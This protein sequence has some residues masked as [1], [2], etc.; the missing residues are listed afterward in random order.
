MIAQ[1]F[2]HDDEDMPIVSYELAFPRQRR[3][4]AADGAAVSM[5]NVSDQTRQDVPELLSDHI[6]W[7]PQVEPAD[8]LDYAIAA[9]SGV[10]AGLIDS[11][12]VGEFSLDHAGEWG[13][14]TIE[15]L[16][17]EIARIEGYKGDSLKDAI[18]N[19]EK[20][21]PI[22]ADGNTA[23]F[24][25]GRQ[26][27]LRD[28]AHHF[29]IGGLVASIFTQFT[30]LSI[31]TD[32]SGRLIIMPVPED[33]RRYLGG[34]VPEKLV[35]GTVE[36]FFH[37]VS[38]MAGSSAN[39]GAGTGIPGPLLS[40]MKELS[41][42]PFFK[43][44]GTDGMGFRLWLSK[45]FNGTFL[46]KHGTDGK[47]VKGTERRFD[48]RMEI[49]VLGEVGRQSM[50][51]VINQCVVRAF[52]FC[53]RLS[54]GIKT[55]G[56]HDVGDIGRIA[57][58]DV[59]P[60]GTPAMRR[61]L[62]VSNGV[63]TGVDIADAAVHAMARK[64]AREFLLRVNYIGIATFV[65]SCVVDVKA[66]MAEG[67]KD[68]AQRDGEAIERGLTELDCLKLD[69]HEARL[70]HSLMRQKVLHDIELEKHDKH[71]KRKRKWLDEWS[72]RLV[73]TIGA[74]D[75]YFLD[76]TPLYGM[77]GGPTGPGA[78]E[79]FWLMSLEL[80]MFD[81]YFP[82][83]GGNDKEYG[84]LKIHSDYIDDVFCRKQTIIGTKELCGLGRSVK[85]M[86]NRLD[87]A[88]AK[89]LGGAAGVVVAVAATGGL[90]FYFAPAVAPVLAA[91]FG[92]EA[93][94]LY[95]AA[96]TSASLAFLG[97]GALAAGGAGMAGGTMLIMGGGA[98][99][100]AAG[101]AG[102]SAATSMALATNGSYVLE[103]CSKLVAFCKEVL[104]RRYD[105][106]ASA[107]VVHAALNRRILELEAKAEAIKRSIH[108]DGA[109]NNGHDDDGDE[110]ISPKK[111]LK[112]LNR[113]LKYLKRADK[114]LTKILRAVGRE[115][116][117]LL[118]T[119]RVDDER[120][121]SKKD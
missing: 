10:V 100:G 103:E 52:Y 46:T 15:R 84:K 18:R 91:T 21:H 76:E 98:V 78:C 102:M 11:L 13:S 57:P 50:P 107:Y 120:R 39:A 9:S 118:L 71:A 42:L 58:E 64:D 87:G 48:L 5:N 88:M 67:K 96:L 27:H 77:I 12:F 41:T 54:H 115:N 26:H 119:S 69:S 75:G 114:E 97:G 2:N 68:A 25:G 32:T 112:V 70:L 108:N 62:T 59:L 94:G 6:E 90:A 43:E 33:H 110:E 63:F 47:I 106:L 40:F 4:L 116:Q 31:G 95:G 99:L 72:R 73:E 86:R 17:I 105:D 34:N 8:R 55:F 56:I 14:K 80:V 117:Q 93:A 36:W 53:R 19:L 104:I 111:M 22:A 65:V 113:S 29:S 7:N 85:D 44:P 45:L 101:G 79:W 1:R 61:M 49:G 24:G 16:V 89:R 20:A 74:G 121:T 66:A 83:H 92:F 51:V 38:D 23:D 81:P 37:M 30:G 28:F 3:L 109:E 35:F 82:L 60:W